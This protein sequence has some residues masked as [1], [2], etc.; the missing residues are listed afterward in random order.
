MT[1]SYTE[2]STEL[3]RVNGE[4]RFLFLSVS[5]CAFSVSLCAT[6]LVWRKYEIG[7]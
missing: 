3:H 1:Q 2:I 5:L 6:A 4:K 7:L